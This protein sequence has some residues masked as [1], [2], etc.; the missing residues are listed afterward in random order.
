MINWAHQC[1]ADTFIRLVSTGA[2]RDGAAQVGPAVIRIKVACP[3]P[4]T[5]RQSP[6]CCKLVQ[7]HAVNANH[8]AMTAVAL[9]FTKDRQPCSLCKA[10]HAS[11]Q[12]ALAH[13]VCTDTVPSMQSRNAPG[14][15]VIFHDKA[16]QHRSESTAA[17]GAHAETSLRLSVMCTVLLWRPSFAQT[18]WSA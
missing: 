16:L 18:P 1:T 14:T 6:A 15:H 13:K 4:T 17:Q 11:C 7:S 9:L 12:A 10:E 5:T 3:V 8:A 2:S